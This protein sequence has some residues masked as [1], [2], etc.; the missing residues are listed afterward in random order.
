MNESNPKI[1]EHEQRLRQKKQYDELLK[2][3]KWISIGF[4]SYIFHMNINIGQS[5]FS[6]NLI[7]E[8]FIFRGLL[9]FTKHDSYGNW[10][11]V[12]ILFSVLHIMSD[13]VGIFALSGKFKLDLEIMETAAILIVYHRLLMVVPAFE[14]QRRTVVISMAFMM[15]ASGLFLAMILSAPF[16]IWLIANFEKV[17]LLSTLIALFGVTLP[18]IFLM[19][20]GAALSLYVSFALHKILKNSDYETAFKQNA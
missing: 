2:A 12:A 4:I 14:E 20:A 8:I 18:I 10:V 17:G 19:I 6:T 16:F 9:L 1:A 15:A 7:G 3:L 11:Y 13:V 5:V